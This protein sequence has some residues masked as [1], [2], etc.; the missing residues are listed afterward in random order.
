MRGGV[1]QR[2]F[3]RAPETLFAVFSPE[4]DHVTLSTAMDSSAD[5]GA[6]ADTLGTSIRTRDAF[7]GES[8]DDSQ[9]GES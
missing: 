3:C 6:W 9:G 7:S 2:S 4:D 8:Q 5:L 1:Y